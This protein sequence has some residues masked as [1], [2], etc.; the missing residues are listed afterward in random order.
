M[1]LVACLEFLDDHKS[2]GKDWAELGAVRL[3]ASEL[4]ALQ[5]RRDAMVNLLIDRDL[6]AIELEGGYGHEHFWREMARHLPHCPEQPLGDAENEI[7]LVQE[8]SQLLSACSDAELL[9]FYEARVKGQFVRR[10]WS[11]VLREIV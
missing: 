10:R 2:R 5:G 9:A 1:W 11:I 7:D 6:V 8:T 4:E 3:Y